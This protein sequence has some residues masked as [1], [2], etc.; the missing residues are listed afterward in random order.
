[1]TKELEVIQTEGIAN[2]LDSLE[3][4]LSFSKFKG[5]PVCCLSSNSDEGRLQVAGYAGRAELLYALSICDLL[6]EGK[7]G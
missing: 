4:F 3:Q 5:Y 6:R 2:T 1:M 7:D